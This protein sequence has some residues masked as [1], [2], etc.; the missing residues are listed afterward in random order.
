MRALYLLFIPFIF[1]ACKKDHDVPASPEMLIIDSVITTTV[2]DHGFVYFYAPTSRE[3]NWMA[4]YDFYNGTFQ[5]RYEILQYPSQKTFLMNLCIWSD[6]VGNWENYRETCSKQISMTGE[7]VYTSQSSP[8]SW[9]KLDAAVDFS[10]VNDF[11][12]LGMVLWCDNYENLSD[13]TYG[14][15]SCW[16]QR[17]DFLPMTLRLTVVAVANGYTFRGW[18]NYIGR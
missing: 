6:V 17:N 15:E 11:F 3:T 13:W 9:W 10:R 1:T 16:N 14:T 18:E 4:P 7:G 8:S 5:C 12:S 2:N